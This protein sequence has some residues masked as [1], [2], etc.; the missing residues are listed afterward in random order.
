MAVALDAYVA[1]ILDGCLQVYKVRGAITSVSL[2]CKTLAQFQVVTERF[3]P[4]KITTSLNPSSGISSAVA[5][6][7][8]DTAKPLLQFAADHCLIVDERAKRALAGEN[9]D[10]VLQWT[11]TA[12]LDISDDWL[13]GLFDI[14]GSIKVK[15][16]AKPKEVVDAEET[17]AAGGS[18]EKPKKKRRVAGGGGVEKRVVR[19]TLPIALRGILKHIA[20]ALDGVKWK[21]GACYVEIKG[22]ALQTFV[23]VVPCKHFDAKAA[24]P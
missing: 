2:R 4:V 13:A 6:Y 23:E 24:L 1:G 3:T 10:R 15:P 12:D 8:A 21:E 5:L 9:V 14:L 17:E 18:K 22:D 20:A 16:P 19:L 7:D 11:D